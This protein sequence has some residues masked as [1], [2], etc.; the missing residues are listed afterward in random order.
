MNKFRLHEG[1]LAM[2]K[3]VS[4]DP[5]FLFRK[6]GLPPNLCSS[7]HRM[8]SSEQHF[9]LW[10]TLGEVSDDPAIGLRMNPLNPPHHPAD[11][12]AQH[13]RTFGDALG[14][15]ARSAMLNSSEPV[16]IVSRWDV[17]HVKRSER[18]AINTGTFRSRHKEREQVRK[19]MRNPVQLLEQN[20][21]S[22]GDGRTIS[23]YVS[24][25]R[26]HVVK[27]EAA[28]ERNAVLNIFLTPKS[29]QSRQGRAGRRFYRI[30]LSC[31]GI[32]ERQSSEPSA[33]FPCFPG[34][35]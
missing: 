32:R 35:P 28:L 26:L 12:A 2:L 15:L 4:I 3:S 23:S 9:R 10:H 24:Y 33:A 17:V 16:R 22:D 14:Y 5:A 8:I 1:F 31:E 30:A 18:T 29:S 27:M 25:V 6:S 13:A 21:L 34:K 11:I 19:L 7:G 20:F